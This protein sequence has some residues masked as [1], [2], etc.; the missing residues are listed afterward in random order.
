M[1]KKRQKEQME[2]DEPTEQVE[3]PTNQLQQIQTDSEVGL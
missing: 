3:L 2:I 1:K